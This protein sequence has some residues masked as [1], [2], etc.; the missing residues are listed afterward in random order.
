[1]YA[2]SDMATQPIGAVLQIS[3]AQTC[4]LL[5]RQLGRLPRLP[6]FICVTGFTFSDS[7][8]V[9]RGPYSSNSM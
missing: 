5:V 1:V 6:I 8:T 7:A 4:D 9:S 2:Y 3:L